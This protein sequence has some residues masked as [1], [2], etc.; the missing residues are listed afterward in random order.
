MSKDLSMDIDWRLVQVFVG[1]EGVSEVSVAAHDNRKVTCSCKAFESAA[2]CKHAQFVKSKMAANDGNYIVQIPE[3]I[4]DEDA[5]DA[6]M[7]SD[8]WREFVRKHAKVEAVD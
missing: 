5:V 3:E 1:F 6:M 2:R 7:Y 8:T 4:P